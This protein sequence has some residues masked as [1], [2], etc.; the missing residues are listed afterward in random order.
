MAKKRRAP[1]HM[2]ETCGSQATFITVCG[3]FV[4]LRLVWT[5]NRAQVTCPDCLRAFLAQAESQLRELKGGFSAS[6]KGGRMIEVTGRSIHRV[7][8]DTTAPAEAVRRFRAL[9]PGAAVERVGDEALVALCEVC[10]KPICEGEPYE[11]DEDAYL[12]G[13][14]C[15][16]EDV[17]KC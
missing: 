14:C 16:M 8:F 1:V 3:R 4:T 7:E 5:A 9:F 17:R 12:C 10:G 15:G 6:E 11:T 2:A 13:E